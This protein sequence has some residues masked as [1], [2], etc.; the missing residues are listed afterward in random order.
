MGWFGKGSENWLPAQTLCL[1]IDC[2]LQGVFNSAARD[3][4]I[5]LISKKNQITGSSHSFALLPF[6]VMLHLFSWI[7][8]LWS[9]WMNSW[10]WRRSQ[11]TNRNTIN[12][13]HQKHDKRGFKERCFRRCINVNIPTVTLIEIIE[14]NV[15]MLG[16][17]LWICDDYLEMKWKK[18][19]RC[20]GGD[21]Q[22]KRKHRSGRAHPETT[23]GHHDHLRI[24][25][26]VR[27]LP[28]EM[29]CT[30]PLLWGLVERNIANFSIFPVF[31]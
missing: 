30:I 28:N 26:P 11:Q 19:K 31:D 9:A 8:Q 12:K 16:F 14:I 6:E 22:Q 10:S 3:C 5:H 27:Q 4:V 29:L 25:Q 24:G 20:L 13:H 23:V 21:E 7:C 18:M 2:F 17:C 15:L 1:E